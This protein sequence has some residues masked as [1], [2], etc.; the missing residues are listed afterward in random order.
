MRPR[1]R[2]YSRSSPR[3]NGSTPRTIGPWSAR[4]VGKS[5]LAYAVAEKVT[6]TIGPSRRRRPPS[7]PHQIPRPRES[8]HS[9]RLR[10]LTSRRRPPYDPLEI[11]EERYG[12]R[13][14]VLTSRVPRLPGMR[15]LATPLTPTPSWAV[16]VHSAHRTELTDESRPC[17]TRQAAQRLDPDPRREKELPK[18][19]SATPRVRSSRYREA[20]SSR[21]PWTQ[22]S[23]Y[24]RRLHPNRQPS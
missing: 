5:W 1:P 3:A 15:S 10:P 9:R 22:S 11:R 20:A 24:R 4:P 21:N 13:S 7:A 17:T 14:T 19:T 18:P 12:G 2:P 16:L 6:A 23:R 8:A